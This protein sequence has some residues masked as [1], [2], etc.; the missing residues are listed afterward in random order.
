MICTIHCKLKL[1]MQLMQGND[2]CELNNS[3]DQ[4]ILEI[5]V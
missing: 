3:C 4:D 5:E 2:Y 1:L